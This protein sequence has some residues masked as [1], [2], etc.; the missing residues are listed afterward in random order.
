VKRSNSRAIRERNRKILA[1]SDICHICGKPGADAVDHVRP[2][3]E[4]VR[5]GI[6]PDDPAN[7]KPA[8]H[9][10]EPKCNRRKSDKAHA[11]IVRR[12]GS[13]T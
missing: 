5:L 7:L 8:H 13:L 9:D 2:W 4:C 11:P 6:N 10:V 12:S 3:V 1:A